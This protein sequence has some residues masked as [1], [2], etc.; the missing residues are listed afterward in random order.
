MFTSGLNMG[1]PLQAWV[2]IHRLSSK[3]KFLGTAASKESLARQCSGTW[4][5]P[6]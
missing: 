6:S 1:L 2:E 4:K 3:E 5:D